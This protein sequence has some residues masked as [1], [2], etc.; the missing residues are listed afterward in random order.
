MKAFIRPHRKFDGML[1]M[2]L[3]K[4]HSKDGLE[5]GDFR[6]N[7]GVFALGLVLTGRAPTQ[8][9]EELTA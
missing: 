1:G 9:K 2:S 6:L 4:L 3:R 7:K 5:A 8:S